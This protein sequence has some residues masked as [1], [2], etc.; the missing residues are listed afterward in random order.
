MWSIISS[1]DVQILE[2]MFLTSKLQLLLGGGAGDFN[3]K[4]P[5]NGTWRFW[6]QFSLQEEVTV[7]CDSR[8]KTTALP[9][10][11]QLLGRRHI[12]TEN[13]VQQ[14]HGQHLRASR[15]L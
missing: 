15:T 7:A 14:S 4:C 11:T 12:Q 6:F 5:G 3:R 10:E 13:I 9:K 8:Q 1:A 2:P